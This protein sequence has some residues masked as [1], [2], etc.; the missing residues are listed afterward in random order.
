MKPTE[1][2]KQI[3]GHKTKWKYKQNE[4]KLNKQ[5]ETKLNKQT[6][7]TKQ[8]KTNKKNKKI[9]YQYLRGIMNIDTTTLQQLEEGR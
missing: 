8:N 3:K 5:N 9:I 1:K 7:K 6:N 2:A 4:T